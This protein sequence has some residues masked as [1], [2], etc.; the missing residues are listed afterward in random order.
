MRLS[1]LLVSVG[2][3]VA[4]VSGS[5]ARAEWDPYNGEWGKYNQTD[6]RIM[7]WNVQDDIRSGFPN[8]QEG[9]YAWMA[10]A[11]IVAAMQPDVLI[12][13]EVGDNGCSNC[14]DSVNT[15]TNVLDL[16]FHGGTDPYIAGNP[17]VTAYVQRYAPDFDMPYVYVS[18]ASDAFNRNVILSRF[19]FADL[20]GDGNAKY[21]DI[22]LVIFADEYA[23][24]GGGGIRGF[25]L[26][27]MELPDDFYLGDLVVCNAHLKSGGSG[28]DKQDRLEA[29]QNTAYVIDYWYNGAGTGTPDPNENIFDFPAATHI[30]DPYTPVVLGGDWNEDESSNGR[31]GPALW[32]S[33]AAVDGPPDGTDRDR[34]DATYDSSVDIFTGDDATQS[35]SKLDYICYQDSIASLRNQFVFNTSFIPDGAYPPELADWSFPSSLSGL[36]SDHKPVIVDLILPR[37]GD[38]NGDGDVDL[39]DFE[40]FTD[41]LT[42]PQGGVPGGCDWADFDDDEDVDLDDSGALWRSFAS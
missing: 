15:L 30:L 14:V 1:K 42:G 3:L 5:P 16:F 38:Q 20:N 36:A 6:V 25:M 26:S 40:D 33:A 41:C 10:L 18:E 12:M 32:L 7:T 2:L 29:S 31:R 22:P 28:G 17:E 27:E 13:Q 9:W 21:Y 35:S 11:R 34:S 23:P 37:V 19:P 4:V 24:S 39:G 8:K